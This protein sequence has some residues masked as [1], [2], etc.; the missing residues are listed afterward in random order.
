M[1]FGVFCQSLFRNRS[2]LPAK[3]IF[4]PYLKLDCQE[5]IVELHQAM[6]PKRIIIAG[7]SL[8]DLLLLNER[9]EHLI[10]PFGLDEHDCSINVHLPFGPVLLPTV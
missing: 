3:V 1:P 6:V 10:P 7:K 2:I 4:K 8:Y 5:K 9:Y